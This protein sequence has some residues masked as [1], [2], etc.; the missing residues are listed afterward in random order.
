MAAPYAA[1]P[2]TTPTPIA[3]LAVLTPDC[4]TTL[5]LIGAAFAVAPGPMPLAVAVGE[6][7][8]APSKPSVA[9]RGTIGSIKL[10]KVL[11]LSLGLL[12]NGDEASFKACVSASSC[13]LGMKAI[14]SV[15]M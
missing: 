10:I 7:G 3:A 12:Y 6:P 1:A 14:A 13:S 5:S 2:A 15:V 4:S 11:T 9:R 8:L